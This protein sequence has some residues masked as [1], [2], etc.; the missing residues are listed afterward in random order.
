MGYLTEATARF[1]TAAFRHGLISQ[2]TV[3]AL[4]QTEGLGQGR[5]EFY[6]VAQP[7]KNVPQLFT[8]GLYFAVTK[9]L[10]RQLNVEIES[11]I[12]SRF[13]TGLLEKLRIYRIDQRHREKSFGKRLGGELRCQQ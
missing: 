3:A 1:D 11:G 12:D 9:Q 6:R 5:R 2:L 13:T 7:A 4:E 8:G 10:F